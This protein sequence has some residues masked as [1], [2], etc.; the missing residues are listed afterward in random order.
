MDD[1]RI[2]LLYGVIALIS[3]SLLR[4][5]F[6]GPKHSI[7]AV[8]STGLV[9]SYAAA[10]HY[11][12]HATSVVQQGYE[13]HRDGVFRV[14]R[15]FRWDFIANGSKR[16]AEIAS[17][18]E[19]ILSFYEGNDDGI[20]ARYTMGCSVIENPYHAHTV[21]TSLTRNL[22]RCFPEVR[23]E[24][25]CA[26]DD[27][28]ALPDTEW[29]KMQVLP[30]MMQVVARTSNRL[31]VG[32]PLC[33]VQEFL[34]LNI[35]FTIS[36]VMR[37]MAISLI[38]GFLKPVLAPLLSTQKRS[39][40]HAM[41]FLGPMIEERLAQEREL[42]PDW[43]GKPNDLISWL[44]EVAEG[45]GRTA[46]EVAMRI[47]AT[48]MAAIHTSSM[49][50]THA[51]YDL[52]TYPEHMLPMREEVARVVKED[53]WTK[54]AL[55]NMHKIDSFI[56]ESQRLNGNGPVAMV[57]KVV[58]PDGFTFSDGTFIPFGSFVYVSGRPVHHDPVFYDHPDVFDGFRFSK[59]REEKA[60]APDSPIFSRH[61]VSTGMDH[62]VFGHGRHACPG[63]F[64]AATELKAMLA[65]VLL[66]YDVKAET[67]GVRPLDDDFGMMSMPNPRANI[68]IR[69]RQ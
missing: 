41:R 11:L 39:L 7:P 35:D 52:T 16:G 14:P 9:S 13:E 61:M 30:N 6:F 40:R 29:K 27:V 57:R 28:L 26:F 43:P 21:R 59:M 51:L 8:G 31:F 45:E 67:E 65:H 3:L 38:P 66:N 5:T 62:L 18:P 33:R 20:Q 36:V 42:G 4:K 25:I 53:G 68:M 69:K 44:L 23:D 1:T 46:P 49:A 32:L 34:Q 19:H 54:A 2:L 58:H 55:N 48:N 17:A 47:L 10:F 50:L 60:Q 12:R 63:R 24:I 15:P 56:R 22:G 37:G 64:F